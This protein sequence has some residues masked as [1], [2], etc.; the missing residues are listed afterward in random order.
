MPLEAIGFKI[1]AQQKRI[2]YGYEICFRDPKILKGLSTEFCDLMALSRN[3]FC[4]TTKD[5]TGYVLD[6]DRNCNADVIA[7]HGDNNEDSRYVSFGLYG[8]RVREYEKIN[9]L[10]REVA[11]LG[12]LASSI[13]QCCINKYNR[14]HPRK[15]VDLPHFDIQTSLSISP[16]YE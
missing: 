12:V 3:L 4:P 10:I 7:S 1:I 13:V 16:P 8:S 11:E 15:R 6:S 9:D 5:L 14:L 2:N